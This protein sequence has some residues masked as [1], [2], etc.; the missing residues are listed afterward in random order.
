M[1]ESMR[2]MRNFRQVLKIISDWKVLFYNFY[3]LEIYL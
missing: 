3:K 2:K 1:A